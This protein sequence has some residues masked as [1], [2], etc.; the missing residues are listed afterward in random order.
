MARAFFWSKEPHSNVNAYG[1][2]HIFSKG[3]DLIAKGSFTSIA[4]VEAY[5]CRKCK[6]VIFNYQGMDNE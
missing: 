4:N 6:I 3:V 2:N 1:P 5:R